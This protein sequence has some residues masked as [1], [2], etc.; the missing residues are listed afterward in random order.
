MMR[1]II[2]ILVTIIIIV[3][4]VGCS[5][6]IK[7]I[8]KY[9]KKAIAYITQKYDVKFSVVE[10]YVN[11][12][13]QHTVVVKEENNVLVNVCADSEKPYEFWDNYAD[14]LLS[15]Q[16]ADIVDLSFLDEEHGLVKLYIKSKGADTENI[17]TE[18]DNIESCSL[19]VGLYSAPGDLI[20][21]NLYDLYKELGT[22]DYN[23]TTITVVFAEKSDNFSNCINN[24]ILYQEIELTNELKTIYKT[25]NIEEKNLNFENFK[26]LFLP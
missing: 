1:K 2:M 19:V 15:Y 3:L 23:N 12:G 22:Y 10:S 13:E 8:E 5:K 20:V 6:Q 17:D 26:K 4:C 18:K 7:D 14:A 9:E 16:M 25:V 24:Y 11:E 21:R